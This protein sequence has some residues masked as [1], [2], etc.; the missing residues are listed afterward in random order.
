LAIEY[1]YLAFPFQSPTKFS[2][3]WILGL[4]IYHL[5]TLLSHGI[6]KRGKIHQMTTYNTKWPK[7]Y[8]MVGKLTKLPQNIPTSSIVRPSKIYPNWN[9]WFENIPSGNPA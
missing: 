8:L 3:I 2:Q 5:A 4:K 1:V 9:F 7:I 6:Q